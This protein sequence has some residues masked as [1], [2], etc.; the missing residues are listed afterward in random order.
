LLVALDHSLQYADQHRMNRRRVL[1]AMLALLVAAAACGTSK[2][3]T[4]ALN[5]AVQAIRPSDLG[6]V[7]ADISAGSSSGDALPSRSIVVAVNSGTNIDGAV[8][9]RMIAAGFTKRGITEW[10]RTIN[11]HL[12]IATPVSVPTESD[13]TV[14]VEDQDVKVPRGKSIELFR[15][16]VG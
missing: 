4:D 8:I 5:A 1:L 2:A 15:I 7:I 6:R 14:T 10:Q 13:G 16:F 3:D 9:S 11:K 12:V